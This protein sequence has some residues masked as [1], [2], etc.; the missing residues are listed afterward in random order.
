MEWRTLSGNT[1]NS[2]A[3]PNSLQGLLMSGPVWLSSVIKETRNDHSEN[4]HNNG[5]DW[6]GFFVLMAYQPL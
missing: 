5:K 4:H 1:E 2:S 3:G 6:F